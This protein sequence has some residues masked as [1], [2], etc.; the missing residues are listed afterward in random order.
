MATDTR[1]S[2]VP[3]SAL[4]NHPLLEDA[5]SNLPS[6]L[7]RS[8]AKMTAKACALCATCP[9]RRQ[10]LYDAVVRYDVAGIVAGTT[11]S[12]RVAIRERLGWR[13]VA[14]SLDSLLGL[15]GTHHADHDQIVRA[16][17]TNP[18]ESLD[19]LAERLGVSLST[20]KRHLRQERTA[21]KRPKLHVVPPSAEQVEQALHDITTER[22]EFATPRL[23]KAA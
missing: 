7:R 10:C 9:I 23:A 15:A 19:Q 18:Q 2:C 16:R 8:R 4:F 5:N 21:S 11:P 6:A 14:E 20:V 13:V 22:R 17:R 12:M 1:A 3:N